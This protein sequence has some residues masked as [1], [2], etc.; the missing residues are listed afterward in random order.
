M[1]GLCAVGRLS[2]LAFY[3]ILV[4]TL[5]S[6]PSLSVL[7]GLTF[8]HAARNACVPADVMENASPVSL[9]VTNTGSEAVETLDL[10][11]DG[12][13]IYYASV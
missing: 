4:L 2:S 1:S 12:K 6:L 9:S 8:V 11:G 7:P 13:Y 10:N 3:S 5:L